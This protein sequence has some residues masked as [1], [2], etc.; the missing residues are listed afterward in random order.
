MKYH[1]LHLPSTVQR[2]KAF[3]AFLQFKPQYY[4][5]PT[6]VPVF[7]TLSQIKYGNVL[8]I[9]R[10]TFFFCYLTPQDV[11][12]RHDASGDDLSIYTKLGMLQILYN[13]VQETHLFLILVHF[14]LP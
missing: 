7:Q 4:C 5:V 10:E 11:E 14:T 1:V 9:V 12:Q 3:Q 6:K 2:Q 13:M 8:P